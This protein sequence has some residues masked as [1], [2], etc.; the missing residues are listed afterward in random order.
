MLVL[1]A[2]SDFLELSHSIETANL[3]NNLQNLQKRLKYGLALP[4]ALTL[5]EMGFSDRI[6]ST[7]LSPIFEDLDPERDVILHTLRARQEQI[8]AI[9][10]HYPSYFSEV[11]R[12]L[13][14]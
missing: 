12:N 10:N 3:I 5:Y 4:T 14:D 8:F 11:Y 13:I 7:A 6:I 2:V 9:L 1:G